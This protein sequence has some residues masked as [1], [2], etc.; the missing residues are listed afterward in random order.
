MIRKDAHLI[1][2]PF[3]PKIEQK[4]TRDGYGVGVVEAA[5]ADSYS[6]RMC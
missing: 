3:D 4:P 1:P 6:M 2:K 5:K